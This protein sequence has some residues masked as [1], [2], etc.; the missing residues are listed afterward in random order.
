MSE[1]EIP[2]RARMDDW[3]EA[4]RAISEAMQAVEKMV[5][6]PRLTD[7]IILLT[8]AKSAVADFVDGVNMRRF[9]MHTDGKPDRITQWRADCGVVY[10]VMHD[11]A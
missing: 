1:N 9:V 7:A 11:P 2:R 3:N 10:V 5:A 6:D 4:E 8:E